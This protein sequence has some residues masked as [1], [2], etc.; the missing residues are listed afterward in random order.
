MSTYSSSTL[1]LFG[2]NSPMTTF[3][4]SN[5]MSSGN[6]QNCTCPGLGPIYPESS[7]KP[8]FVLFDWF[9][10]LSNLLVTQDNDLTIFKGGV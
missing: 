5:S 6:V 4:P 8:Q 10:L 7:V 9:R 1:S 2:C 3:L